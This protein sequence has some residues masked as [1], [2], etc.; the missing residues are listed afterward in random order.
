M[1]IS[2]I[3]SGN[4]ATHLALAFNRVSGVDI[5]QII[6]RNK[7]HAKT[8]ATK[9]RAE[10]TNELSR[11]KTN[12]DLLVIS[13]SDDSITQVL[14]EGNFPDNKIICHTAGS[15]SSDVFNSISRKFGV[16]YPLQTFTKGKEINWY[17]VPFFITA[18]EESTSRRLQHL[19]KQVSKKVY[20]ISDE[21]RAAL[22]IAAVFSCNFTNAILQIGQGICERNKLDFEFLKP[23]IDETM[24]KVWRMGAFQA[25]TGPAKRND[26]SVLTK[27]MNFLE[28]QPK[29]QN[30][31]QVMSNYIAHTHAKNDSLP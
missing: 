13:T 6:S 4:V 29:A 22:H 14:E 26:Q 20:V 23:L 18:S 15:V 27:H 16:I 3:G 24:S 17:E 9:V 10:Y 8:L 11:L 28:D 30:I 31:Y 7:N 25:Q 1:K 12:F 21:A 2:F 5:L 19:A